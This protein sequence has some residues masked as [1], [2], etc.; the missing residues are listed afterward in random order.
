MSTILKLFRFTK[1]DIR[2][3]QIC[4]KNYLFMYF[5]ML[6]KNSRKSVM[7]QKHPKYYVYN[8]NKNIIRV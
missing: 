7:I 5:I 2:Y 6:I 4:I 3:K 8:K 1:Q